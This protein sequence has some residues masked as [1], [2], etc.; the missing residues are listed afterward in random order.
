MYLWLLNLL[1]RTTDCDV[2]LISQSEASLQ[3]WSWAN[4]SARSLY[5]QNDVYIEH[6]TTGS[7]YNGVCS[8]LRSFGLIRYEMWGEIVVEDL[9]KLNYMLIFR[10]QT[11]ILQ[12]YCL[13]NIDDCLQVESIETDISQLIIVVCHQFVDVETNTLRVVG[14]EVHRFVCSICSYR[15][16]RHSAFYLE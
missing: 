3:A 14:V 8:T 2:M 13:L 12:Y 1:L 11:I 5:Y 15:L 16:P 4:Q 7:I 9:S 10:T 6:N